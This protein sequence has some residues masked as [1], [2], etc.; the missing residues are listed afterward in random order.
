ML[1]V[2]V[3]LYDSLI[4]MNRKIVLDSPAPGSMISGHGFVAD[5]DLL[6]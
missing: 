1:I 6:N 4:Q 2:N 3:A 5:V